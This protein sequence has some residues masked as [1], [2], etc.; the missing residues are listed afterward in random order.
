D[1][2]KASEISAPQAVGGGGWNFLGFFPTD[3]EE[4]RQQKRGSVAAAGLAAAAI[5]GSSDA[6]AAAAAAMAAMAAEPVISKGADVVPVEGDRGEGKP[7]L[8]SAWLES[9]DP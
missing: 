4:E 3:K 7:W 2:G 6:A 1:A 9:L 5:E 8:A